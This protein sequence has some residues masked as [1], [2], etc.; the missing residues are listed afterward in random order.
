[1]RSR[2]AESENDREPDH[3]HGHLG[4]MADGESSRG[5]LIAGASRVGRARG[6]R[7][8]VRNRLL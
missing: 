5:R 3:P 7:S 8:A 1:M 2:E 4:G 6:T